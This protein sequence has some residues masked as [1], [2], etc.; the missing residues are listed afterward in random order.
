[1][2]IQTIYICDK[3]GSKQSTQEQFWNVSVHAN[4]VSQ[5]MSVYPVA[6]MTMQVCR[7]CLEA[8]G[9]YTQPKANGEPVPEPL[10]LEDLIREIVASAM[11]E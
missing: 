5:G 8:F 11:E 2:T 10:T 1:M 7:H 4:V 9:I 6:K 3:C